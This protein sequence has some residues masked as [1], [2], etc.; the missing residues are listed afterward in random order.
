[1][2]IG[3]AARV[4]GVNAKMIRH[5]E[6]I[7]IIP[8]AGRTEAGY[9]QYSENE[10]HILSFVKRSRSLGF[11][12]KEIKKLV[13]LWRNKGR[14][15]SDVKGLALQHISEM[16]AKILELQSMVQTL[17]HLAKHCHGDGRP[18]CPILNDLAHRSL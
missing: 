7:G 11:S 14:A 9:R 5:Y 12:M 15:S 4:S 17:K 13:S 1:M 2:N 10:I 8:K 3:E 6:S 18:D 16:E